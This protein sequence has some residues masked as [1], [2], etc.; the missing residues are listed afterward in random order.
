MNFVHPTAIVDPNVI[1]G[2][3]NYIG[4]YCYIT[5]HTTIGNN[6]RFEGYCSIGTPP[7]HRDYFSSDKGKLII[8]NNNTIRE[9]VTIH[10]GT[11]KTTILHNDIIILNHSHVAHDCVLENKV[12]ISASVTLAGHVYVMEGANVA[13]GCVAHNRTVVGA[14]SMVGM[15]STITKQSAINPG[16]IYVGSPAKILKDNVV[17]LERNNISVNDLD[18]FTKNYL[19]LKEQIQIR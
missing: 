1:L 6:N 7:E 16:K 18:L 15:N 2:V 8:G 11:V 12:N 19:K 14:Y 13:L 9:F 5:G 4:P 17:G 10:L 3:G